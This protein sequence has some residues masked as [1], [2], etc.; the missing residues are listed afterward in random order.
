MKKLLTTISVAFLL[1]FTGCTK[2]GIKN[3]ALVLS[4]EK[5]DN[6]SLEAG[7]ANYVDLEEQKIFAEFIKK[8][9][10]IDV[11]NVEMQND[12]EATA[13]LIIV[14][15]P[16]SVY[17]ELKG[18]SGKDWKEKVRGAKEVKTYNI[19]MKKIKGIWEIVEQKEIQ[20]T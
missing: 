7:K 1:V 5:F 12:E 6:E 4:A 18:I 13:R 9:T 20:K 2:Q 17:A 3:K 8:N 16:K 11:D 15:L 10:Q 19:K 14:T